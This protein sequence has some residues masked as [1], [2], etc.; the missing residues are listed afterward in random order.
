MLAR[1]S[2]V[3]P[4]TLRAK[5]RKQTFSTTSARVAR[6]FD[7]IIDETL[8]EMATDDEFQTAKTRLET[9][10]QKALTKEERARR[11]RALDTIGVPSF[12]SYLETR[13]GKAL[14][15]ERIRKT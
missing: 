8:A 12:E 14:I 1:A 6:R 15:R 10:G 2:P 4:S 3:A 9:L 7:S 5:T 11:R 13:G